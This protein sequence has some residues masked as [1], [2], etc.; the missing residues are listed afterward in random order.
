MVEKIK[1][2]CKQKGI[3]IN[4]LATRCGIGSG[5]IYRWDENKPSIDKVRL[6]ADALDVTVNDLLDYDDFDPETTALMQALANRPELK[7]LFRASENA[8]KEDIE[9]IVRLLH[10][11]G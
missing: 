4:E 8:T 7:I 11:D 6:V 3:S 5:N 1:E 2:Y 10:Y 9:A